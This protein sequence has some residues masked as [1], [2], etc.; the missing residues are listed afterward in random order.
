MQQRLTVVGYKVFNDRVEGKNYDF[1]KLRVMMPCPS[2]SETQKGFD[3]VEMQW[4]D[5]K[6]AE[7]LHGVKWPAQF[8][9]EVEMTS[10]GFELT[11]AKLVPVAQQVKVA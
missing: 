5:H 9:L 1:T 2:S 8:D 11:D 7:K 10:K 4:G 6:N 3:V